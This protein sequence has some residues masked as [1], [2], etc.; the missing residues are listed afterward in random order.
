VVVF[1]PPLTYF[2]DTRPVPKPHFSA[3]RA[4]PPKLAPLPVAPTAARRP[5]A[6]IAPRNAAGPSRVPRRSSVF[7]VP[8]VAPYPSIGKR[9]ESGLG[10][11]HERYNVDKK[12][13]D[14]DIDDKVM[15]RCC[16][17]RLKLI[18]SSRFPKQ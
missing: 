2:V 10:I 3:P 6:S 12:M 8:G 5:R 18:D 14:Q 17:G 4:A 11:V 7:H 15:I 1:P 13:S 16:A 9:R